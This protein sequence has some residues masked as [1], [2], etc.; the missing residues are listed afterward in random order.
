MP[1]AVRQRPT[2]AAKARDELERD[3]KALGFD[4]VG[5]APA[6]GIDRASDGLARFLAEGRHG[7]MGWME[8]TRTRRADP[9]SL[10]PAARTAIMVAMNYGPGDD[11]DPLAALDRPD[12]ATI[13]CYAHNRDYHDVIKGRLKQAAGRFAAKTGADVKVFVDTA[14]LMEK[15]L[16]ERAGLGWQG[17]HTNLLSRELGSWFFLGAILTDMVLPTDAPETDHCGSCQ[18]CL[19]ICPTDAF[20]APYQ[21]DARRCISYLTIEHRGPIPHPFRAPIGNRVYGCD[22]CLAVCPWNKFARTAR[23]AKLRARDDMISPPLAEL[24][25]LDDAAFRARFSGSSIKRIGRARFVRNCLIAAGN[26]AAPALIGPVEALLDDDDPVVRGAA[27]WALGRL[28]PDR[29]ADARAARY[30]REPDISVR[31]EWDRIDGEH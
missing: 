26:S 10:W 5:F 14:P 21:L 17:K 25:A 12:R 20:P 9:Q 7:T 1:P 11:Y 4:A 31:E 23:E 3:L 28:A 8:E 6:D 30:G 29:I 18:A 24:L 19:D 2:D 13:S 16:A 22:D 27:V 15:P